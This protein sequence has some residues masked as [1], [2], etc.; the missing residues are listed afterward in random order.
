M[1]K[2]VTSMGLINGRRI[3]N[4]SHPL[5]DVNHKVIKEMLQYATGFELRL[6]DCDYGIF[7]GDDYKLYIEFDWHNLHIRVLEHNG[8]EEN[9]YYFKNVDELQFFYKRNALRAK[10]A[11]EA[12]PGFK[13]L[14][15][16]FPF[17]EL[18]KISSWYNV[19]FEIHKQDEKLIYEYWF[20]D[21][22]DED[23]RMVS[24]AKMS[25]EDMYYVNTFDFDEDSEE[26]KI[27][28]KHREARD[29]AYYSVSKKIASEQLIEFL[30]D[31][32]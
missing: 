22:G 16:H 30:H 25:N 10:E 13:P 3:N 18:I 28:H 9:T 23:V 5:M 31:N 26:F 7:Y 4:L 32:L 6:E 19:Y 1:I 21:D 11:S 29:D 20:D 2:I 15:E 17:E 14:T 27:L 12:Y 24:V 8:E